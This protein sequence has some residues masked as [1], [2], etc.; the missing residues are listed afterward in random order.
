MYPT[1]C[2]YQ[3]EP[4]YQE[5]LQAVREAR[6]GFMFGTVSFEAQAEV[7]SHYHA[8]MRNIKERRGGK[9]SNKEWLQRAT[10][11]GIAA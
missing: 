1:F 11:K 4:E 6:Q 7:D 9:M 2:D 8:V 10:K 3:F 5:A